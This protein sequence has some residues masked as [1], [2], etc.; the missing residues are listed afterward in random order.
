ME[1]N[2]RL[3]GCNPGDLIAGQSK[4]PRLDFGGS[5]AFA[6]FLKVVVDIVVSEV[7][8]AAPGGCRR[9]V[10]GNLRVS[11]GLGRGL[12]IDCY[13]RSCPSGRSRPG[14]LCQLLPTGSSLACVDGR[15]SRARSGFPLLRAAD[16]PGMVCELRRM[17]QARGSLPGPPVPAGMGSLLFLGDGNHSCR[18]SS[19]RAYW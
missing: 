15:L 10:C 2:R 5:Q 11:P 14:P 12:G 4:L 3:S 18:A 6:L 16:P 8:S 9:N 13:C 17:D 1:S 7:P 19:G